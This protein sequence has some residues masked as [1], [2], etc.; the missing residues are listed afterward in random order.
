MFWNRL[1]LADKKDKQLDFFVV[2]QSYS[3]TN[4]LRLFVRFR[5]ILLTEKCVCQFSPE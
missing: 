1:S 2:C 5:L 3:I 4:L